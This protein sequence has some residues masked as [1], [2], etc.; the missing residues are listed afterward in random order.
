MIKCFIMNEKAL[1]ILEYDKILLRLEALAG[2]EGAKAMCRELRPMT[3][4]ED[5]RRALQETSDASSRLS[6]KGSLSFSGIS[7][8]RASVKRAE[9]GSS[10]SIVE[11]LRIEKLLQ[12][13]D[14]AK[15]YGKT[16]RDTPEDL[17]TERFD[18]LEPAVTLFRELEADILS[19][20]EIAD[21]ASPGL[22]KVRRELRTISDRIHN[23]LN[24][25]LLKNRDYLQDAVV[26]MRDG[27]YCLPVKTE[28]KSQ[29]SGI[30]HD[31]SGSGK[32][33]FIEPMSVV[34]LNNEWRELEIREQKEI[35]AV[36]AD[37]SGKVVSWGGA[38]AEDWR[39]LTEL[40]FIFAKARLSRDMKGIQ[41]ELEDGR[42][43]DLKK[44][45]HPLLDPKTVVPIDVRL[46]GDYDQLIITGPNTG[47]K[48]VSLKTVGLLALMG[49]SGL[50]I[51]A[52]HSSRI[53]IFEEVFADIGDE[54][55]IEQ[56]LSTFSSHMKN[57]VEIMGKA[58]PDSLCLFDELGAGTDPTE[59][60]ALAMAILN[61]LHCDA[62]RTMATTHYSELKI[63]ALNTPGVE[64]A[65]CEFD[66]ATLRPTYR[67]LVGIPGKS[68]AF[69]IAGKLGLDETII[70]EAGSYI[71]SNEEAFED[72]IAELD[73]QR[74]EME[75]AEAEIRRLKRDTEQMQKE[76]EQRK[77]SM[78]AQ[79]EK[80]LRQAR[81]Q[82][83]AILQEAKDTA[84]KAIKELRKSGQS[85]GREQEDIRSSLRLAVQDT[86]EKLAEA[87]AAARKQRQVTVT[88]KKLRLGDT[89]HVHSLGLKGTVLSLPDAKGDL[90]VQMGIL[91]SK[92]NAS[93]V[94]LVPEATTTL[95]GK[96]HVGNG[97]G[98]SF[99]KALT[100][101]TEINLIG[102][103]TAEAIPEL[104]KYLD[105]C[106]LAH[107]PSCRVVHGRGTGVL[108]K[109]VHA[110]LKKLKYVDSFR[111]GEFGEGQDGVTIV[112]F[113]K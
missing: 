21:N 16:D 106:Y 84:D 29:V 60:A 5:I 111:L 80:L 10:L 92:V 91:K 20:E 63:Y 45:R 32:A 104:Q 50:H 34:R 59:G 17:L 62:I 70:E 66:V 67:L 25:L 90:T 76:A 75:K 33:L 40:D 72:V 18:G 3:E 82:A 11:L 103:T 27:R 14:R 105:D 96:R 85:V 89:V 49:Q 88:E 61:R 48:T 24:A 39:L 2:S 4:A 77:G 13:A 78:E 100:I 102:Q 31:Q 74:R 47:G 93:D 36:L 15:S 109:A 107:L 42:L 44:A 43:L 65:S 30:V 41:P 86:D 19:E 113:K 73:R 1:H 57:I 35:E 98:N 51:P 95:E 22:A 68:N 87:D 94:E 7:D 26:T 64:N 52:A 71:N 28:H 46:G 99:Q 8:I 38:I 23:E 108:R 54:Q 55:S 37:L 12:M 58:D 81:E 56:S 79:R 69:A 112:T 110:Q 101:S 83:R 6:A 53:P 9:S 97:G